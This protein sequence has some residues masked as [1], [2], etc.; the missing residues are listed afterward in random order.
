VGAAWLRRTAVLVAGV[1]LIF[2]Q[3]YLG[4]YVGTPRLDLN[5][6]LALFVAFVVLAIA[7]PLISDWR[8][9][10]RLTRRT[11]AV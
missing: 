1:I 3:W 10:R 8:R 7:V 2:L 6:T 5:G 9:Q 4:R 11:P